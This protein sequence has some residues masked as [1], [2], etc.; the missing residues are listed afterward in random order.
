[1]SRAVVVV[2]DGLRRDLISAEDTSALLAFGGAAKRFNAHRSVFPSAT[3]VVSASFA[4][5]CFPRRHGLQGNSVALMEGGR[6]VVRD[7]GKP[8]F[9]DDWRQLR[10]QTLAV[11]TLAQRIAAARRPASMVFSNVSPGAARAHDPDGHGWVFHRACS[12]APG[13]RPLAGAEAVPDIT[14]DTNGDARLTTRFIDQAVRGN[15]ALSV[16]WLGEPDHAQHEAPLGSPA[17]RTAI[18]GADACF[19]RVLEAVEERRAL[20]EDILLI[21]CSDHGHQTVIEVVDIDAALALAGLDEG[22]AVASNGTAA[23]IYLHP[24]HLLRADAI[25]AFLRAQPWAGEVISGKDLDRIGQAPDDALLCA[26]SM[27]GDAVANEFGVPGR[28]AAVRPALGKPDRLGC[29]QH[30]GLNSFEQMPFLMIQGEGFAAGRESSAPT[31]V[32]DLAPT[33]LRHLGLPEAGC[34]GRSL[35]NEE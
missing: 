13:P 29:G 15:A 14:L 22:V 5:G 28:A 16:L 3:R 7:V 31:C 19:N 20:G 9:M 25:L 26:V 23:L 1:M 11:P 35:Q 2:L 8:E 24:A 34:G 32:V 33:I 12:F 6:L 27:C 10:G 17:C 18:A 4:T 21:A 30:G